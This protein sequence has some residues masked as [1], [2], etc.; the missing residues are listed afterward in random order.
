MKTVIVVGPQG[1]GKTL[2]AEK[3]RA[4]FGCSGIVDGW[5]AGQQVTPGALHLSQDSICEVRSAHPAL[6]VV[7]FA[8]AMGADRA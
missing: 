2:N 3:L 4:R 7:E 6:L 5:E 8:E 1:C